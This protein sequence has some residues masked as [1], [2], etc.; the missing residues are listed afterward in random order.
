MTTVGTHHVGADGV[1]KAGSS[2]LDTA[3]SFPLDQI[4]QS[5]NSWKRCQIAENDTTC[6][7]QCA[8]KNI[9]EMRAMTTAVTCHVGPDGVDKAGSSFLDTEL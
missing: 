4:L 7:T 2:F 6:L 9:H 1:E 3:L 8:I 5:Y